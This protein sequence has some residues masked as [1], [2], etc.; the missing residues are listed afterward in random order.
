L[1]ATADYMFQGATAWLG[2]YARIDGS[3][4]TFG[5]PGAWTRTAPYPPPPA[6]PPLRPC[7]CCERS[8]K[9][10]GF[11]KDCDPEL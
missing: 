6:S 5:P 1:T 9:S 7:T 8:M 11:K 3:S 4:S 2:A 10:R